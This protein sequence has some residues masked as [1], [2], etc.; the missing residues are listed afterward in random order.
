MLTA[1]G[2]GKQCDGYPISK[3]TLLSMRFNSQFRRMIARQISRMLLA[4]KASW[5]IPHGEA[6]GRT[7]MVVISP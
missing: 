4:M 7:R 5:Q 1:N 3:S 2:I 6:Q